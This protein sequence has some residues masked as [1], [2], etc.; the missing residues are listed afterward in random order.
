MFKRK[1]DKFEEALKILGEQIEVNENLWRQY[2]D[3]AICIH[4]EDE[5]RHHYKQANIYL[6]KQLELQALRSRFNSL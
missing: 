5:K 3:L 6:E 2:M 1:K 4:D